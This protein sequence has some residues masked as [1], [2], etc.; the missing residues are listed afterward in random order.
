MARLYH[1]LWNRRAALRMKAASGVSHNTFA[2]MWAE[3]GTGRWPAATLRISKHAFDLH[4]NNLTRT[5]V[6][7][8]F[9]GEVFQRA[10]MT[11]IHGSSEADLLDNLARAEAL[12]ILVD[13][14]VPLSGTWKENADQDFGLVQAIRFVRSG[15]GGALVPIAVIVTKADRYQRD[16]KKFGTLGR[17]VRHYYPNLVSAAADSMCFATVAVRSRK[18]IMDD[19]V[20]DWSAPCRSVVEP[21]QWC[22]DNLPKTAPSPPPQPDPAPEESDESTH[23]TLW[24]WIIILFAVVAFAALIVSYFLKNA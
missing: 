10:F 4:Y 18:S 21:L 9:P 14:E 5:L 6:M 8:D 17:F 12:I 7:L 19:D 1:L 24:M 16:L 15:V 23:A 2:S 3:M 11:D 22:L 13:P 20:P